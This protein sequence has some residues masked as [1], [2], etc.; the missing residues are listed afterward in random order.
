MLKLVSVRW[1]ERDTPG[2]LSKDRPWWKKLQNILVVQKFPTGGN[3][4]HGI[5]QLGHFF[6][7]P[8]G[9]KMLQLFKT[10]M[11]ETG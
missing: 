2:E 6:T 5:S 8:M 7:E 4:K 11:R 10:K 3:R 1:R 9:K